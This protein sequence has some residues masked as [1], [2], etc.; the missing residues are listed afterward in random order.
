MKRGNELKCVK[1]DS[2]KYLRRDGKDKIRFIAFDHLNG[3]I[4]EDALKEFASQ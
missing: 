4:N 3:K 1:E 2:E